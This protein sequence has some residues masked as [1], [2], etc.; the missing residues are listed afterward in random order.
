MQPDLVAR[1]LLNGA[2]KLFGEHGY[3]D[4]EPRR[5]AEAA[6]CS[7]DDLYARFPR[8][9]AF[10][11]G[12]YGRITRGLQSHAADTPPGTV[13]S[14]FQ[15]LIRQLLVSLGPYR[16]L[17]QQLMPAMLDPQNRLGVL[18]PSTDHIRADV[19]GLYTL[20][21]LGADDCPAGRDQRGSDRTD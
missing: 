20:L 17:L 12:L 3:E 13:A 10:I 9:Q 5:I 2:L 1:Q 7:L 6:G 16:S 11:M 21:V 8:K 15:F 14:R 19:Q 4:V 18:G